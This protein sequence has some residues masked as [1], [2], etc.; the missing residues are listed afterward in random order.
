MGPMFITKVGLAGDRDRLHDFTNITNYI[1]E[2][3]KVCQKCLRVNQSF[4][5][6][7]QIQYE[8]SE[9]NSVNW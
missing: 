7:Y 2:G 9:A 4:E 8:A 5:G 6:L 3:K 1:N